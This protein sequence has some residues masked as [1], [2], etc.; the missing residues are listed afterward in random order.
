MR[1]HEL[2]YNAFHLAPIQ[3]TGAS[4]SYYSLFSHLD[5]SEDLFT[6]TR[7]EK[8]K[9]LETVLLCLKQ[10]GIIF[11]VDIILNHASFDSEWV[12]DDPRTLFTCDNTPMLYTGFLV[13]EVIY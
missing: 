3:Q 10:K 8:Y 1:Q 4:K 9:Q 5:L 13:D 2:G 7:E 6:G 12:S 11:F